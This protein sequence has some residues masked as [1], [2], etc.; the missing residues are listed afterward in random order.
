MGNGPRPE[1]PGTGARTPRPLLP[2]SLL[3]GSGGGRRDLEAA[4][5]GVI[6]GL[7]V[8]SRRRW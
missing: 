8:Q 4:E 6:A 1:A 7:F 5:G 3:C 2:H